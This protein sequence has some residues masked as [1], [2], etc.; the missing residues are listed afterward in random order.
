MKAVFYISY[1]AASSILFPFLGGVYALV[2]RRE[3]LR[4][5]SVTCVIWFFMQTTLSVGL[6]Y[7]SQIWLTH[8]F[9]PIE[10]VCLSIV[11][12]QWLEW[13]A[14]GLILF[15]FGLLVILC[16][17]FLFCPMD[18]Y[19]HGS[20]FTESVIVMALSGYALYKRH[21]DPNIMT[22]LLGLL[23]YYGIQS[24]ISFTYADVDVLVRYQIQGYINIVANP[25]YFIGLIWKQ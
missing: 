1:L 14:K 8:I 6:F 20:V 12:L 21:G 25:I 16:D 5:F 7:G 23:F 13:D 15:A 3:H 2:K 4:L 17:E 10:Y 18:V 9:V 19:A 22:I 24:F 11:V